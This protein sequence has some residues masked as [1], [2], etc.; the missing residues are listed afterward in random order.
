MVDAAYPD[1]AA[2]AAD[3][4]IRAPGLPR[5]LLAGRRAFPGRRGDSFYRARGKRML[6][7]L[8]AL[9]LGIVLAPVVAV[10]ALAIRAE[11]A[12][13]AVHR[14]IRLGRGGRRFAC[15]KLRTMDCDAEA[16]L[17][18][19]LAEDADAAQ[20]WRRGQKLRRDPRVTSVGAV[21]RATRIDEMPQLWNVLRGEMSL[22]GPRPIM[23]P[24]APGY[25]HDRAYF[26]SRDF[27][28]YAGMR[29]GL[30]GFWQ[31]RRGGVAPAQAARRRLD[32]RY[33]ARMGAWTD[34]AVIARTAMVAIR[35]REG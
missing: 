27:A 34:L 33:A 15:L 28:V 1:T 25:P 12:G 19:L 18:S 8:C 2:S 32:R 9:V 16:R 35:G 30:T 6:D 5:P 11:G 23:P 29:P 20:E 14:Q 10:A 17:L 31:V 22:V 13:P 24:E 4:V 7:I 21:L 3:R 26:E